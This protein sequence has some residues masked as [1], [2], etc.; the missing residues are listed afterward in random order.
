MK[1][2][3][4][5]GTR[6]EAVKLAPVIQ[7]LGRRR[8]AGAP[9]TVRVVVTGQHR[10]LLDAMLTLFGIRPDRDLDIMRHGQGLTQV[11]ARVLEGL[12]PVLQEERPDWVVVQGDTTSAFAAA[13]AAFYARVPVAHVEAG[14]RTSTLWLPYPEEANRRLIT[15]LAS[16]HLAATPRAAANLAREGV[17]AAAV[18]ITGNPVVDA[19]RQIAAL[20]LRAVPDRDPE[21]PQGNEAAPGAGGDDALAVPA[22]ALAALEWLGEPGSLGILLTSHRRE[23]WGEPLERVCRAVLE[24]LQAEP[25][26]RVLFPCHPNPRVRA[27]AQALLGGHER[28]RLTEPLGYLPFLKAMERA[29]LILSDSGGVQEEAPAFGRPVLVLREETERPE[30]VQAGVA[31]LVGTDVR[32]IV[33][34]ARAL[35]VT[36]RPGDALPGVP[37]DDGSRGRHGFPNPFG[38]GRASE[39][40]ASALL[41]E[42]FEPF[43]PPDPP[44]A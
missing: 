10:E 4:V 41:G 31:R 7:E 16:L 39:R 33:E 22:W 30:A 25:R 21:G 2:L 37:A 24:I 20:P 42:P 19:L 6:P 26:A 1:A 15:R 9:A 38:D 43:Q 3:V 35:L 40:I 34:G 28:V 44:A 36:A 5:F 12:E 27:T 23:N 8:A 17:E 14:L 11:T 32:R 13:L 29:V 18:R